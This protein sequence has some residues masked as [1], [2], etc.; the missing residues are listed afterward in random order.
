ME[1]Q[2]QDIK[3]SRENAKT[4][5]LKAWK[6]KGLTEDAVGVYGTSQ[7][8]LDICLE[9]GYIPSQISGERDDFDLYLKNLGL[10]NGF[11]LY[12]SFPFIDKL[13]VIKPE[14]VKTMEKS[15]GMSRGMFDIETSRENLLFQ[16]W[17]YAQWNAYSHYLNKEIGTPLHPN[18]GEA[19]LTL[20]YQTDFAK[21]RR[22][23]DQLGSLGLYRHD[24]HPDEPT[25]SERTLMRS[26]KAKVGKQN[27]PQ[28]LDTALERRGVLVFYNAHV[29]DD[30]AVGWEDST[31]MVIATEKPLP[32]SVIS[33]IERIPLEAQRSVAEV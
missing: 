29:L 3:I 1:S 7:E 21:F 23:K 26:I 30:I 9:T 12:F 33:G 2:P 31:E 6:E 8:F 25:D 14:F 28:F 13:S 4:E 11:H 20:Q 22:V 17:N 24:Y 5:Q 27:L 10:R 32:I 16:A 15:S 19:L 18:A